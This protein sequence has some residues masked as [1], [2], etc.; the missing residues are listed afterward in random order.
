MLVDKIKQDTTWVVVSEL[1]DPILLFKIIKKFVLKQSDNQ[2]KMAVLI[3]K[4]LSILSFHQDN[5]VPNATYYDQFTTRVEVACQA[6]VCYNTLDLLD[7]KCV[8]LSY[9]EYETLKPAEQKNVRDF[10]ELEYLAY[11]FINISNQKLHSQLKKDVANNYPK[12]NI[13][14]YPSNIHK[15]LTLMNEY[16]PL[17]LDV[18]PVPAQGTAFATTSWKGKGK[19]ASGETKYIGDSHWKTMSPGAQTTKVINTCKKAVDDD[20][21]DT[22]AASAKSAKTTKSISKKMKSQ[23]KDNRRLKKSGSALQKCKEDDDNALSISSAEG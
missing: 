4:Q 17:K 12:G 10:V 1:F 19:K 5:Q 18:A 9:S 13:E 11:L 3:A 14:V 23:E 21:D 16:K 20:E 8:E 6:G 2:Y 22:S 15:A 7:T